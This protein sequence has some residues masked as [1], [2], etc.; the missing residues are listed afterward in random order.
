M[1]SQNVI[2]LK[3]Y[4]LIKLISSLLIILGSI[5]AFI[6][7]SQPDMMLMQIGGVQ[8]N[9]VLC[10]PPFL[11]GIILLFYAFVITYYNVKITDLGEQIKIE[12]RRLETTFQKQDI[13]AVKVRDAGRFFI[14]FVFMFITFYFE[15]YGIECGIY[16]FA[17]HYAGT[18]EF[19]LIPLLMIWIGSLL[20]FLFPRKLLII[21][22][23]EKAV[24][25]KINHLPKDGSFQRL[26]DKIMGFTNLN[27]SDKVRNNRYQY[28]L[29]LGIIFILI[30]T[31]T[32]LLIEIDGI[33]QPLHDLGIFIPIFLLLF[34]VLMISSAIS[35]GIS[36]SFDIKENR[37]RIEENTLISFLS[38]NNF[39][40]IKSKEMVRK[41][42][43]FKAGFRTL[44][45]FDMMMIFVIFG[46]A[47]F[48]A[49]KFLWNPVYYAYLDI[50]D[51]LIG[52]LML[53]VLFF[54]Q[55]EI[56]TKLRI[57]IDSDLRFPREILIASQL[58]P[59]FERS[60]RKGKFSLRDRF[61]SYFGQF[62]KLF[63][64]DFKMHIF[65]IGITYIAAILV[66]SIT[67][68]IFNFILFIFI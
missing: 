64:S 16:W 22:M 60:N 58:S 56:V 37:I 45:K 52:I 24:L 4:P 34:G 7:A 62:K 42:D 67:L 66:I 11:S 31:I 54:Y 38:G 35:T 51:V 63:K 33:V 28:R 49:F 41:E 18:F 5:I 68:S 50:T 23:K 8:W 30:F 53:A 32:G 48:L 1:S 43:L 55:F 26:I 61:S 13:Q 39:Y 44:T 40:W 20:L 57:E 65:K 27:N 10:I 15:Y 14:G 59:D 21:L 29:V 46:Q 2:N 3:S 36:Q 6:L 12:S 19:I 47:I 9:L 17:N 25:Q